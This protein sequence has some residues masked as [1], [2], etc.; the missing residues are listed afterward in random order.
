MTYCHFIK[1]YFEG[2]ISEHDINE[3]IAKNKT[4][5]NLEKVLGKFLSDAGL[6]VM[7]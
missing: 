3:T 1:L 7:N 2:K 4:R 5:P 6:E